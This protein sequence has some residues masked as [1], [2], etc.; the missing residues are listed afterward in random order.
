MRDPYSIL[1][2]QRN[3][4]AD[5]IKAAWRAKAKTVHPD[6]NL[7]DPSATGKFA[8]VGQAYDMLKDPERR[9]R[10]DQAAEMQQTIIQKRQAEREKAERAKAQSR[11]QQQNRKARPSNSGAGQGAETPE[12][13]VE[14]IFG[15]AG[16]AG[17]QRTDDEAKGSAERRQSGSAADA[18][19]T[20]DDR[21][22]QSG[23]DGANNSDGE[24]A[25]LAERGP[26]PLI[27]IDLL[28]SFVRRIRGTQPAPEKSPDLNVDATIT[29]E[30]LLMQKT[31]TLTLPDERNIRLRLENGMSDGHVVRISGQGL[32][33]PGMKQGDVLATLRVARDMRYRVEG[34]NLHTTLP[35]SLED[36]VLGT[37]AKVETPEGSH[38]IEIPSWSGS[39][40]TVKLDGLGLHD[41]AGGRGDLIVELR[42]ILWEKPDAKVTDLMRHMR[43]GLY[44]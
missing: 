15:T 8:E 2:V 31:V 40:Q 27:A 34:F 28:T 4:D 23:S 14:R 1:G 29:V 32:K 16:Q 37:K 7:D 24:R 39:D 42:I 9:K 35:I 17:Q 19:A 20:A 30:D 22:E 26:L 21:F 18:G 12:D 11:Q 33:I 3:A 36:A 44:V 43:H 13:I 6:H 5:E 41:D 10:Y 38:D 25:D